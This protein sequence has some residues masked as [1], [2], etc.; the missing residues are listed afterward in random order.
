MSSR[1]SSNT[2]PCLPCTRTSLETGNLFCEACTCVE[3]LRRAKGRLQ[4]LR[5]LPISI[6]HSASLVQLPSMGHYASLCNVRPCSSLPSPSVTL[7]T[8]RYQCTN[9]HD[10]A[11]LARWQRWH[12]LSQK[13]TSTNLTACLGPCS[14]QAH[15]CWRRLHAIRQHSDR[16]VHQV[17]TSEP[18]QD[19]HGATGIPG[20]ALTGA[21]G[22]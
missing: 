11:V 15:V 3:V 22:P 14:R 21:A 1:V 19:R 17:E 4:W 5:R 2:D 13:K 9:D 16:T 18:G 10:I 12:R 7:L 20:R 6:S 8:R